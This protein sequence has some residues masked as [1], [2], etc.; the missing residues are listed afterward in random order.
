MA[1]RW[2]LAAKISSAIV[3]TAALSV[4]ISSWHA[5]RGEREHLREQLALRLRSI[6]VTGALLVEGR[7]LVRG[8]VGPLGEILARVGKENDLQGS[9]NLLLLEGG[10]ALPLAAW[11]Q[12]THGELRL[13]PSA[14]RTISR[15]EVF[16]KREGSRQWALAPVRRNGRT[17]ALLSVEGSLDALEDSLSQ[18]R[19][20][21][22][23]CALL[24]G[25]IAL[26]IALALA[27]S[28]TRPLK[29]LLWATQELSQGNFDFPIRVKARDEIGTLAQ[30]F[31]VMKA[32]LKDYIE[33]QNRCVIDL[34]ASLRKVELL[35]RAREYLTKFVPQAIRRI[36]DSEPRAPRLEK[37]EQEVSVL[38]LDIEGYTRLSQEVDQDRMNF[39]VERYFSNY[40]D[41]IHRNGGDI[42]ET[43]G[44]GLMI[45]FQAYRG[46]ESHALRAA[47]TALAIKDTT[48]KINAHEEALARRHGRAFQPVCVNIGINSGPALVGATMLEGETG[49]RWTYTATG[50][51]T[52]LA[53]RLAAAA[54]QGAIFVSAETA[55]RLEGHYL[56][57][58]VGEMKFKNVWDPV[59][60]FELPGETAHS[61]SDV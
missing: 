54:T 21:V 5:Y 24:A 36:I 22:I 18:S 43:S 13:D 42:N 23:I 46:A 12:G 25:A 55:S 10:R 17:V 53:A 2:G 8:E 28:L 61:R 27:R 60:V 1:I 45:L 11:G 9:L 59:R 41:H 6:A 34:E 58:D 47:A 37:R 7:N 15:G 35:E 32:T 50:P 19:Q 38:F 3:L 20:T 31:E 48:D 29:S 4:L 30:R 33:K 57:K 49:G 51:T 39:L 40:V 52:N 44:D 14:K 26:A 16:L 56:L